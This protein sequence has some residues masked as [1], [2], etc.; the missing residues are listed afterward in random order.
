MTE[1]GSRRGSRLWRLLAASLLVGLAIGVVGTLF[2]AA[3]TLAE[4]WRQALMAEALLTPEQGF[5][6]T[7]LAIAAAAMLA[8]WLVVRFAPVAAG[9]GV[10]H[11]EAVMRGEAK[12]A[13]AAVV[14]VKFLGGLLA[15]GAGLPLGREGP[16]VQM[17]AVAGN[18]VATRVVHDEEDRPAIMA[19]GAGAGLGVA[20]NAPVG[21][22]VFVFEEVARR[23][24]ERQVL[25]VLAAASVA[26]A[27]MRW[28]LGDALVLDAGRPG[29]QPLGHLPFHL[30]LG[31]LLGLAGAA[32]SGLTVAFLDAAE[33]LGRVPSVLRAGL[34]GLVVGAV[35][36]FFP[37]VIGSGEGLALAILT[38]SEVPAALL[39]I[40]ALRFVLGPFAYA[41]GTPG[42]L[43][44]PL[45]VL[46]AALGALSSELAT[47]AGW[48]GEIPPP[49]VLAVVGMAAMFTAV[50][51]APLTGIVLAVEMTGRADC[52]LP[53]LAACLTASVA[54]GLVGSRPIYDVLRERMLA[55]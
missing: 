19:A 6:A 33:A 22:T 47:V 26:V 14:P 25:T 29:D 42:G 4:Q 1:G 27:V 40:V 11:V 51:R 48:P 18:V 49:Q 8:R 12:P 21:A 10:Q 36:W 7:V 16:T 5:A 35:G 39:A 2:R 44:A 45:L 46:G 31:V 52:A 13:P 43:F 37:V 20:F 3:L 15:I 55:R 50:V 53:M 32:Y 24:D 28:A 38:Q 9:S 34:I 30:L 23:F 54:A 41:A 17:G